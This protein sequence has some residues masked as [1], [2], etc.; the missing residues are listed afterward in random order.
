FD[1]EPGTTFLYND[2]NALLL[3]FVLERALGESVSS[4][5]ERKLWEPLGMEY[6]ASWNSDENGF[7]QMQSG[8]N[9]RAVEYAKIGRLVLKNGTWDNSAIVDSVWI[10][11]SI[12]PTDTLAFRSGQQWGYGYL[13]WMAIKEGIPNDIFACG[14]M[15]QFIYINP[16][17][18]SL[19]IRNGLQS[20]QIDDDDWIDIFSNYTGRLAQH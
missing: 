10:S 6:E 17:S 5:L 7:E 8:L 1:S 9:A 2:Y 13:W 11:Q 19:I 16:A 4:Y 18:N 3:G 20:G 12:A 15:G 14:N